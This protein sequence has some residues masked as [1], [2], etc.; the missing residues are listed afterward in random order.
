MN[1]IGINQNLFIPLIDVNTKLLKLVK[2]N[3]F[4]YKLN[5]KVLRIYLT[6]E[7][8]SDMDVKP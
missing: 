7:S 5:K 8:C 2:E 4:R 3:K 6:E 1:K